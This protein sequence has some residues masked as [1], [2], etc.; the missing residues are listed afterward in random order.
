MYGYTYDL[1][2]FSVTKITG[3]EWTISTDGL[4]EWDEQQERP[5]LKGRC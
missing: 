4:E 2:V 3:M 1:Q 5:R